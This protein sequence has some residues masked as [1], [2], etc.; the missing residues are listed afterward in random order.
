MLVLSKARLL[1]NQYKPRNPSELC[2]LLITK[3]IYISRFRQHLRLLDSISK[4]TY[5]HLH[6]C[7]YKYILF[8]CP[9]HSAEDTNRRERERAFVGSKRLAGQWKQQVVRRGHSPSMRLLR[10]SFKDQSVWM[11][12]RSLL[13]SVLGL[14]KPKI[15]YLRA[16]SEKSN[17]GKFRV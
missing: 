7:M 9:R 6:I 16:F 1:G 5:I 14:R 12:R 10:L 2:V 13:K 3:W 4:Q 15:T 11:R 17:P 8:N